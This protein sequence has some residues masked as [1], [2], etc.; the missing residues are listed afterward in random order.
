MKVEDLDIGDVVYAATDIINDGSMPG[1]EE[2]QVLATEGTRGV[3]S[4]IGH[5]EEDPE[6]MVFLIR[7]EDQDMNLGSPVGCWVEDLL[8]ETNLN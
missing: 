4:M 7:F 2:N 1:A 5:V 6:R 3:I 8:P